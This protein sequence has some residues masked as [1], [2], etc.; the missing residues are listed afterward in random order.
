MRPDYLVQSVAH[1]FDILE[2][3]MT[4]KGE[5]S[6]SD[7][8]HR[9]RLSKNNVFRLLTTLETRSYIEQD[10]YRAVYRLGYK[11]LYLGFSMIRGMSLHKKAKPI[12]ESLAELCDETTD[13]VIL[14]GG[15]TI[16]LDAVETGHPL[17][18][19]P[20][21]G[22]GTPAY[23]TAAGKVLLAG[24]NDRGP[25]DHARMEL[26]RYT[27]NT[28]VNSLELLRHLKEVAVSGYA[29]EDEEHDPGLRSVAAPVRDHHGLVVAAISISGPTL[30]FDASRMHHNLAPMV[31][32]AAAEISSRLGYRSE[33]RTISEIT[34]T[35]SVIQG[36]NNAED[37]WRMDDIYR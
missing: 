37:Q 15:Q 27:P 14:R 3:M 33:E 11:N 13:I 9:L 2:E 32:K 20:R 36:A 24:V 22:I 29:I 10:E 12:L 4:G 18:V 7:L 26:K 19:V 35:M 5:L 16:C 17:R 28:I 6:L 25:L 1:A 8:C 30:R 31:V 23:C 21:I 34:R